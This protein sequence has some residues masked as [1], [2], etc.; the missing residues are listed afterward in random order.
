MDIYTALTALLEEGS[1]SAAAARLGVTQSY[2]SQYVRRLE[3]K[4]SGAVINRHCK[5]L[6][7]TELGRTVYDVNRRI[8]TLENQL[9]SY[10]SSY[11]EMKTGCIRVACNGERTAGMLG[12]ATAAFHRA[13]PGIAFEF[14][15]ELHVEQIP[16]TLAQ[17]KADVGILFESLLTPGLNAF[18]LF[19]ERY[20]L[21]I[22]D[23]PEFQSVGVSWN[24]E[25]IYPTVAESD[26]RPLRALPI[27][28]TLNHHER[29]PILSRAL[30]FDIREINMTARQLGVR[31]TMAA[32]GICFAVCQETILRAYAAKDRCRFV[33]LE[34]VLPVQTVVIAW[35]DSDYQSRAV[36]E[37]CRLTASILGSK[38]VPLRVQ[39]KL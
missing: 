35:H 30:G 17:G 32:S 22:P 12:G 37:Y 1:F 33:S 27:L 18:P 15:L 31:L 24:P 28:Q 39:S 34:D 13:H 4:S 11:A 21:A 38:D 3:E 8:H 19:K 36:R 16:E 9:A 20:L 10:C 14:L 26:C 6:E 2:L 29:T 25:G 7:L 23:L 5:P